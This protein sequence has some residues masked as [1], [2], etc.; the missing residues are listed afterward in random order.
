MIANVATSQNWG[1][2]KKKT[3]LISFL[4]RKLIYNF[5]VLKVF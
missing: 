1:K 2:K 4:L 5:A 3:P